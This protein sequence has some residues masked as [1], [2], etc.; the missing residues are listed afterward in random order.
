MLG[1]WLLRGKTNLKINHISSL[2]IDSNQTDIESRS[3]LRYMCAINLSKP[4]YNNTLCK[5]ITGL[6][7][8][9][10]NLMVIAL[11]RLIFR[12]HQM[13]SLHRCIYKN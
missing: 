4:G 3:A 11:K 2:D 10:L 9:Q 1:K 12:A 8:L 13:E 7:Q 5:R 6:Y